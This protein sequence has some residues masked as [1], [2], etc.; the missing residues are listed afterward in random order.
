MGD[1]GG[2]C[3]LVRVAASILELTG[4][5]T[6][7]QKGGLDA[8]RGTGY[9]LGCAREEKEGESEDLLLPAKRASASC[10]CGPWDR[11]RRRGTRRSWDGS[12]W[13]LCWEWF[14]RGC[15]RSGWETS[16]AE[17]TV[18]DGL[19]RGDW[20]YRPR[21]GRWRQL[22][23]SGWHSRPYLIHSFPSHPL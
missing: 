13:G 5:Q 19:A 14:W 2:A 20:V 18:E 21:R 4:V 3:P 22:P 17:P 11:S 12:R 10:A 16:W 6:S 8:Q 23:S 9:G 15:G 1:K 7:I